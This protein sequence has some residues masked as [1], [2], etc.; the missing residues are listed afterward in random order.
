MKKIFGVS[1]LAAFLA[2]CADSGQGG[3]AAP[4]SGTSAEV[5]VSEPGVAPEPGTRPVMST[6]AVFETPAKP[7]PVP[8]EAEAKPASAQQAPETSNPTQGQNAPA[9]QGTQVLPEPQT[10]D[11]ANP[12]SVNPRS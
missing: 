9:E 1:F 3:P 6:N 8:P 7:V 2:A 5:T 10:G 11:D 12:D 4:E